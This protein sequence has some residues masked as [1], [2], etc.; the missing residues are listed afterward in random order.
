MFSCLLTVY[1][2]SLPRTTCLPLGR[3]CC[4]WEFQELREDERINRKY[5][6]CPICFLSVGGLWND[7]INLA[8]KFHNSQL[9]MKSRILSSTE[10]QKYK[11]PKNTVSIINNNTFIKR[12]WNDSQ[13]LS[14]S[15][16]NVSFI[17]FFN[18]GKH[19]HLPS[20]RSHLNTF[21]YN[22]NLNVLYTKEI[23]IT[24]SLYLTAHTMHEW[25]LPSLCL[26][27]FYWKTLWELGLTNQDFP[28]CSCELAS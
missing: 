5:T 15:W 14:N 3:K 16:N 17:L 2:G 26:I 23:I 10:A 1:T 28:F 13:N 24:C 22:L 20:L 9:Q 7:L 27:T 18:Y 25:I 21:K 8:K 11:N 4:L 6:Y 19:K 12:R